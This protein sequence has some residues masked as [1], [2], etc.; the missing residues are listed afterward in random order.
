MER[1]SVSDDIYSP[2]RMKEQREF[3]CGFPLPIAD[4]RS[5]ILE[6]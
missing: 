6:K 4:L 1:Q 3:T 2:W 5:A